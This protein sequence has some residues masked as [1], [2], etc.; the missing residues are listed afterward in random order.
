MSGIMTTK[1]LTESLVSHLHKSK[2]LFVEEVTTIRKET[3]TSKWNYGEIGNMINLKIGE[4]F[5]I[6]KTKKQ[7]DEH[8]AKMVEQVT[9]KPPAKDSRKANSATNEPKEKKEKKV[10]RKQPT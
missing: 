10:L 9:G 8:T 5:V 4:K 2:N 7:R 3:D 1:A 6:E